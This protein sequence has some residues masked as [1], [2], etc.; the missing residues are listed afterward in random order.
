MQTLKSLRLR[1][2]LDCCSLVER[3]NLYL[4]MS[5]LT[6]RTSRN[7]GYQVMTEDYIVASLTNLEKEN[8]SKD[9]D[10][11]PVKKAKLSTLRTYIDAMLGY[12]NQHRSRNQLEHRVS[13]DAEGINCQLA[14][15]RSLSN[16]SREIFFP[17]TSYFPNAV[18]AMGQ[19]S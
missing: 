8:N 4:I 11:V 1:T 14:A 10:K 6:L 15:L 7:P 13:Q 18:S 19:E 2:Y 9:E 3:Q 17:L 16:K 5:K 12:S